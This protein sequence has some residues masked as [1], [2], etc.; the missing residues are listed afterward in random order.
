[1]NIDI[2]RNRGVIALQSAY[3]AYI[4]VTHNAS[5]DAWYVTTGSVEFSF[6]R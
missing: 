4:A 3:T 2:L 6:T 1:M 5:R